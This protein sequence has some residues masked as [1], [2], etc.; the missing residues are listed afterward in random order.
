MSNSSKKYLPYCDHN[1]SRIENIPRHDKN[2]KGNHVRIPYT[3][4]HKRAMMVE[5]SYTVLTSVAMAR[6]TRCEY[7]ANFTVF[8]DALRDLHFNLTLLHLVR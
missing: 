7:I 6:I 3:P 1:Y 5:P 4:H 2:V 8:I